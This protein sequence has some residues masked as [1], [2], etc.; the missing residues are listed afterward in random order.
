MLA[1]TIAAIVL[2]LAISAF[3][4]AAE[5]ALTAVSRGRMHQLEQDGSRAAAAVNRLVDNRE[6][7]IGALL[8]GNTFINILASSLMTAALEDR[9]GPR[10]VAITTGVMTV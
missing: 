1:Y 10:A 9:F 6:G 8:L 2:L 3:F 5:T 4:S 7:M